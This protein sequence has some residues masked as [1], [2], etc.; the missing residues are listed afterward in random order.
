MDFDG[1][2]GTDYRNVRSLN[3]GFLT[4]VKATP[5]LPGLPQTIGQRIRSLSHPQLER[6]AGTPFLLFSLRERDD[7]FWEQLL[8]LSRERDLFDVEPAP[9][10]DY[11]RLLCA[12]LGYIWQLA[13]RNPYAAR[14]ICGASLHW[15]ELIGEL[16]IYRLLAAAG[17]RDDVLLPRYAKNAELWSKLL[18]GGVSRENVVREA[19]QLSALQAVLTGTVSTPD[20]VWAVAACR[21]QGARLKVA[22]D[23][24][25]K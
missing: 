6:L 19:A 20:S 14:L 5:R 21:R 10:D 25:T 23:A 1:P 17:T 9:G 15:C 12:G 7:Q 24:N 3:R 13:W 2:A 11:G 22:D 16:T 4:L 18:D 8:S